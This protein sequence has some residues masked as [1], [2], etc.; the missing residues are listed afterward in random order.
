MRT[1]H[2]IPGAGRLWRIVGGEER[3]GKEALVSSESAA[4]VWNDE[5]NFKLS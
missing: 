1:Y 3:R 4:T 5:K 2:N